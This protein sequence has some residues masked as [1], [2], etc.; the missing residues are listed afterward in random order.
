MDPFHFVCPHCHARLKTRDQLSIGRQFD[1]PECAQPVVIVGQAG[2]LVAEKRIATPVLNPAPPAS[3]GSRRRWVLAIVGV[4]VV[5]A[6]SLVG[7]KA[8]GPSPSAA[9]S[10]DS[11]S[12][13]TTEKPGEDV[14]KIDAEKAKAAEKKAV[15]KK[16]VPKTEPEQRLEGIGEALA[17]W[18][19][20]HGDFPAG[21]I[22]GAASKLAVEQRF[23]WFV[24][25]MGT[26]DPEGK[27]PILKDR[28]WQDPLNEAFVRRRVALL[29]NPLIPALTGADGYPAGHFV[30]IAGVGSDGPRLPVDHP[31][32]GI[33]AND[34]A[35][36]VEQIRDGLANTMLVGGVQD[37]LGSWAAGG[38]ATMRPLAREPYVGGPDGFGTGQA[39]SMFVLMADGRV[40]TVNSKADPA[41]VRRMAAM[42]DGSDEKAPAPVPLA[43]KEL[44][45]P[46][47]P[48]FTPEPQ[49]VAIRLKTVA[50][51]DAALSQPVVSYT[52]P[53]AAPLGL[54][55]QEVAEI[56]GVPVEFDAA[57]LGPAAAALQQ[58]LVVK[59]ATL[60]DTTVAE[61]LKQLLGPSGLAIRAE[62]GRLRLEPAP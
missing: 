54:V 11:P 19:K 36:R 32:A 59:S 1:C 44:E 51:I 52:F 50:E 10:P 22:G 61:I 40:V 41:V 18:R 8:F 53:K 25:L 38:A 39:D 3:A 56:V 37:Q 12:V 42:N 34:R 24:D 26:L 9:I 46:I 28:G 4:N 27:F 23:S 60:K 15:E 55:L 17:A 30:G 16:S 13:A 14:A 33:F 43:Q 20:I 6:L 62:L 21:T 45:R 7:Y 2:G 29:Q 31:R 48:E 49:A 5:L 35:T 58:P 57:Q 47:E